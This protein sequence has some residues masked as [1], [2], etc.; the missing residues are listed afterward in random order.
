MWLRGGFVGGSGMSGF[1]EKGSKADHFH[2]NGIAPQNLTKHVLATIPLGREQRYST[3]VLL[4]VLLRNEEEGYSEPEYP[5][6]APSSPAIEQTKIPDQP[7]QDKV[8]A[9]LTLEMHDGCNA[10]FRPW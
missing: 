9:V 2:E 5:M 8:H 1:S 7:A 3:L 6:Q 10:S 4:R